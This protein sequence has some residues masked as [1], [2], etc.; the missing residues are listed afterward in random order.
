MVDFGSWSSNGRVVYRRN[1]E[2]LG[3]MLS[4]IFKPMFLFWP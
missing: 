1:D 3:E 2:V 4:K